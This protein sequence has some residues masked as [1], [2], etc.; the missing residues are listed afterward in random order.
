MGFE[1]EQTH[2]KLIFEDPKLQGL[3]VTA[4]GL[5]I[6]EFEELTG[7]GDSI[8]IKNID[9]ENLTSEDTGKITGGLMKMMGMFAEALV[10][11]NVTRR[12]KPVPATL[13]GVKSQELGFVLRI[14]MTWMSAMTDV[15]VPLPAGSSSGV[16]SPEESLL[17]GSSSRSLP[18]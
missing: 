4:A 6:G 1:P 14:I 3:E 16:T 8:G 18:S 7:L 12:G 15:D 2:Y 13:A 10:A 5:S 9:P 17:L 11:W